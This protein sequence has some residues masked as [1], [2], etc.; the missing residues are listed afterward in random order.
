MR[1]WSG[2]DKNIFVTPRVS[3][4]GS[5]QIQRLTETMKTLDGAPPVIQLLYSELA[6]ST[7]AEESHKAFAELLP[8]LCVQ[9]EWSNEN[10]DYFDSA[11]EIKATDFVASPVSGMNPFSAFGKCSEPSCRISNARAFA[12]TIGLYSDHIILPDPF[13]GRFLDDYEWTEQDVHDLVT[14]VLVL[15]ELTPLIREGIIHFQDPGI[16]YCSGCYEKLSIT[17]D[18]LATSVADEFFGEVEIAKTGSRISVS[19]GRLYEPPLT[20]AL[21]IPFKSPN[22]SRLNNKIYKDLKAR[23]ASEIREVLF[24]ITGTPYPTSAVFSNSRAAL[25]ALRELEG[26]RFSRPDLIA[27]EQA[28]SANLPWLRDLSVEQV[29]DLRQEASNALPL[30]REKLA[31][32]IGPTVGN[33][34]WIDSS[35]KAAEA[36]R[37]LRFEAEEVAA[38]LK[39]IDLGR[40]KS[41]H[42]VT[43][44]LG[45]S[46]SVY[47]FGADLMTPAIALGTLLST[48]GLIHAIPKKETQ[49]VAKLSSKPGY[50][51]VKAKELLAHADE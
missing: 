48:L 8:E 19:T 32:N 42:N 27:M 28:H 33:A 22:Q 3:W 24:S 11:D 46:V 38:E 13:T 34:G 23:I 4:T 36:I 7:S 12:Q 40:E 6:T 51:L 16:A 5:V 39:A 35:E 31:R 26:Q 14:D 15:K 47:G 49:D 44:I 20:F 10:F 41:F 43:G 2:W 21:D 25:T 30:L 45:L 9:A 18:E 1:G 29:V 17:I 37:E 50:V